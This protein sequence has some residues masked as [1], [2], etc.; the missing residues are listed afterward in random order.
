MR[1]RYRHLLLAVMVLLG[2]AVGTAK[3]AGAYSF[4]QSQPP[5]AGGNPVAITTGPDGALWFTEFSASKIGRITTAG[6]FTEFPIPTA[7]CCPS[8][9]TTGPD[10]ALW[11]TELTPSN[12]GRITTAGVST[13]FP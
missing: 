8:G 1:R 2:V 12:I 5:T 10:G 7:G 13:A 6:V 3:Q 11:F 9:I 4:P